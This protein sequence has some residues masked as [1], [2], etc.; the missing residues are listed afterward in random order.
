V[1]LDGCD[2][3]CQFEQEQRANSLSIEYSTST[4]CP[5]NALGLA[6]G[7]G[8]IAGVAQSTVTSDLTSSVN[9]G[10]TT[11]EWKFMGITDLTGTSQSSGLSIGTISGTPAAAPTGVT[12]N[13][14][15]DLDWWY[16]TA[17]ST[18]DANRNPLSLTPATFSSAVL[19]ATNGSMVVTISL[20]GQASTMALSGVDI[21]AH[22]GK[23]S[24][25]TESANGNTP[26]HLAS[27]HLDPS[28]QSF[29]TMNNGLLC[30]NISAESLSKVPVPSA[31]ETGATACNNVTYGAMNHLLDVLVVGCTKGVVGA[32]ITATQPDQ[33]TPAAPAGAKFKFT[34]DPT[35]H[36]VTGCT[37][38]GVAAT[39][40]TCL[41]GA[42][43]SGYFGFTSDRVIAK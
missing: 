31:L 35:T 43:Y 40:S 21:Q 4:F 41:A 23:P 8:I 27:E 10:T 17:A 2:S 33:L 42:A 37:N 39:L 18:I 32:I 1:N 3:K 6:I 7:S 11:I 25:P 38:N 12:Y 24:A 30:G 22:V 26:G 9:A 14:A 29:A 36:I 15:S 5:S 20:A 16:T 19:T 28:L 13:G 34:A